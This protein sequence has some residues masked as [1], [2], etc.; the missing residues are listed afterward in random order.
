MSAPD[1]FGR[2]PLHYAAACDDLPGVLDALKAGV[3]PDA[4]DSRGWVP[5]HFAAQEGCLAAARALL[6]HGAAIDVVDVHGNTPL[7]V[8]VFNSRGRGDVI[9]LLRERGADPWHTNG[10][11][12]TPVGLARLIGNYDVAQFFRDMPD[13]SPSGPT[14]RS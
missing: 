13:A 1:K 5:L 12:Q 14:P 3:D 9:Q 7:W 2:A 6:D 11:G 10:S 8:A 4:Q